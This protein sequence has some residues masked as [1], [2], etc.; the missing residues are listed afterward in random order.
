MTLIRP[1]RREDLAGVVAVMNAV[2]VATLGEPDTTPEDIASGWDETGFDVEADAFVAEDDGQ[3]VGYAELYPRSDTVFDLD[4][5]V[6]PDNDDA[7]GAQLLDAALERAA[8]RAPAGS[9]LATWLPVGDARLQT[10]ADA[11]FAPVRQF[12]RMRHEAEAGLLGVPNHPD[13]IALRTFDRDA[14]AAAVHAV[15]VAAFAHHVRPMT[16]SLDKFTQQHLD[17]PDFDARHW[18]V[19]EEGDRV[20]GAI[21][22]FNHGDIGFIRHIGV[23][24]SHRGRG[25]G[26]ALVS[27]ALCRLAEAGQTRV[28]LGVDIEDDI[29]AARL[30]ETLGF[31]TLQRLELVERRL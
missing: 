25:I 10:Y 30:Y 23:R 7:V 26:S 6:H 31:A 8:A 1:A 4:V 22:A 29:G 2:D 15:M 5:Y 3:V 9:V 19:A 13:G 17:H 28:D 27:E 18:V 21:S 20:V 14:D 12:V 24:D 16:S 11:G